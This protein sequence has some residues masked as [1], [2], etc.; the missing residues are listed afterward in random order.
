MTGFVDR[1]VTSDEHR[2]YVHAALSDS[3]RP[4]CVLLPGLGFHTFEYAPLAAV[5]CAAGY[6]VVCM[7]YR[8]HGRST[9]P[10]EAWTVDELATDV[11]RVIAATAADRRGPLLLY[12]NS[13]GA[14]VA[15]RVAR[16][17]GPTAAVVLGNCP[18]RV[19]RFLFDVPRRLLYRLLRGIANGLPLRVSVGWL[20][21]YE[22]LSDDGALLARIRRDPLIRAARRL[23]MPTCRNLVDAWD[24]EAEIAALR[25]PLLLLSGRRDRLQPASETGCLLA[26]APASTCWVPLDTGHLPHLD[27]PDLVVATLDRWFR[28]LA[29]TPTAM[30]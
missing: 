29:L 3:A 6:D 18:A 17:G 27:A 15:L 12:G 2:L 7:D 22:R 10:A 28:G 9:G 21:G 5:L 11:R 26:A 1:W 13:L 16:R 14:M 4:L 24:G 20:Y 8:C 23:F 30:T 19:E 25:L